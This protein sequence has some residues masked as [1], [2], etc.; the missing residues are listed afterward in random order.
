MSVDLDIM[1]IFLNCV[2]IQFQI[3]VELKILE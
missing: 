1:D 3:N 2:D